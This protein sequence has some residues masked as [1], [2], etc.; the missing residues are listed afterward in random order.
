MRRK[1]SSV[2]S[3]Y[4]SRKKLSGAQTA[5]E[6]GMNRRGKSCFINS[7]SRQK[8]LHLRKNI[9][10]DNYAQQKRFCSLE[11]SMYISHEIQAVPLSYREGYKMNK[12]DRSQ[13]Y[14]LLTMQHK[15]EEL[16]RKQMQI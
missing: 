1:P 5:K 11:Y 4:L 12:F 6:Q 13:C 3:S 14:D 16:L 7:N 9:Q 10:P 15:K 2:S 8:Y